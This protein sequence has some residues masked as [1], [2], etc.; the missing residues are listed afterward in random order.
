MQIAN[1]KII[2][3]LL[4]GMKS[5]N[6]AGVKGCKFLQLTN[7]ELIEYL[8]DVNREHAAVLVEQN[9]N[10]KTDTSYIYGAEINGGFDRIRLGSNLG[11]FFY[12]RKKE[13]SYGRKS[14]SDGS[15]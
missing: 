15:R 11:G 13:D 14:G 7:Y 1:S 8:S 5:Y 9:I 10:G 12:F 3:D 2:V 4:T 6:A